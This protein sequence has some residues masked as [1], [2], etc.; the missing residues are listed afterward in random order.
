MSP[1][2]RPAN[3]Y[4]VSPDPCRAAA[5]DTEVASFRQFG[6]G[7]LMLFVARAPDAFLGMLKLVTGLPGDVNSA[8]QVSTCALGSVTLPAS[9][10]LPPFRLATAE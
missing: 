3:R 9:H 2:S 5:A 7:V 10:R 4:W 1:H 8:M 6:L